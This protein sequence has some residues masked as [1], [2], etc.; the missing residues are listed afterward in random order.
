[1]VLVRVGQNRILANYVHGFHL[2]FV[3]QVEHFRHDF[4]AQ[5]GKVAPGFGETFPGGRPFR[6]LVARQIIR[7]RRHVA[8]A[9]DVVLSSERIDASGRPAYVACQHGQI[10]QGTDA[11]GGGHVLGDPHGVENHGLVAGGV[12]PGEVADGFCRN[13]GDGL[14]PFRRAVRD[15]GLHDVVAVG[16]LI[17]K[18]LV[19]KPLFDDDVDHSVDHS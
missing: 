12:G 16:A 5:A 3:D 1:M 8:G 2:A 18:F 15:G 13:L 10:G 19:L 11:A 7:Q 14:C 4:A 17:N 6:T 9:L